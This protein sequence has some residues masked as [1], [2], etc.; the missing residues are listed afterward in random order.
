M[1]FLKQPLIVSFLCH[2]SATTSHIDSNK[3]SNCS[4]KPNLCNSAKTEITENTASPQQLTQTGHNF[5]GDPVH[6]PFTI[7]FLIS[8]S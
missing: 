6:R 3:V 7:I 2:K 1:L 5:L 8:G 4:L